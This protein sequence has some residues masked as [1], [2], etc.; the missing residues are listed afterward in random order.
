LFL[1]N[2]FLKEK[3]KKNLFNVDIR[4]GLNHSSLNIKNGVCN[5]RDTN[6]DSE[7]S[8]RTGIEAEIITS[9]NK[10]KWFFW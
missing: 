3:H 7:L 2:F 6:F 10:N 4:L 8:F 9:F 1:R 5:Y